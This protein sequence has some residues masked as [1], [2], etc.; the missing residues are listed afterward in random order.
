MC[1]TIHKDTIFFKKTNSIGFFFRN[2][3]SNRIEDSRLRGNDKADK[4]ANHHSVVD[5]YLQI[6]PNQVYHVLAV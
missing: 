6:S 1:K 3:D 2:S 4:I 5:S